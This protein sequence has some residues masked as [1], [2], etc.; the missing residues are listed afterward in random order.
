MFFSI[1]SYIVPSSEIRA[2]K[3]GRWKQ[4]TTMDEHPSTFSPIEQGK[5]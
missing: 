3:C 4:E 1:Y 2:V 5:L